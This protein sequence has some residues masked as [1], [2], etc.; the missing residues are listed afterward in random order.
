MT[1]EIMEGRGCG[2]KKDHIHLNLSHLDNKVLEETSHNNRVCK[3]F[4]WS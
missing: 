3:K 1:N 2:P 4:C